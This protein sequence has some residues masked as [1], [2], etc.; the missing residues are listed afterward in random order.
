MLPCA[1]SRNLA[2]DEETDET[3][4]DDEDDGEDDNDTS[5][6]LGPVLALG[7]V[8]DGLTGDE[9]AVDGRHFGSVY[10]GIWSVGC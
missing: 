8:G 6:L 7:D 3:D 5:L 2:A 4:G 1:G 10:E 9:G